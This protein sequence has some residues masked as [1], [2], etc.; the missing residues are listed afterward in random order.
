M[1]KLLVK[2]AYPDSPLETSF[3]GLPLK[4]VGE[5]FK[6]PT[7]RSCN[8]SM[9]FLGK[10]KTDRGIE[11]IFMCQNDPG[12]CDDWDADAGGNE[13]LIVSSGDVVSVEPPAGQ[14]T[15]RDTTYGAVIVEHDSNDYDEARA[16]WAEQN[17]APVTQVLGQIFGV[18]SWVQGDE[19]PNCDTCNKP[20][21]FVAQ[22]EEGPDR[23]TAMNFGGGGCAYLFDCSCA[24]SGKF[25]WQS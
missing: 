14:N 21:R 13:V 6:W 9:Q 23:E 7:C 10:L 25:L 16:K 2:C 24:S 19:V 22:L 11:Q 5:E 18:P 17:N 8:G 15:I 1:I 20:M 4:G 12:L 3:G